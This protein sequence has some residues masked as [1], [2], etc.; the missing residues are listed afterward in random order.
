MLASTS[1]FKWTMQ[2]VK[3]SE[4]SRRKTQEFQVVHVVEAIKEESELDSKFLQGGGGSCVGL[5]R[6]LSFKTLLDRLYYRQIGCFYYQTVEEFEFSMSLV[7]H[8]YAVHVECGKPYRL[9][10]KT[11]VG[12]DTIERNKKQ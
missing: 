4:K 8:I 10:R 12:G 7:D 2:D 9:G 3:K 11:T 6:V 5:P 1:S